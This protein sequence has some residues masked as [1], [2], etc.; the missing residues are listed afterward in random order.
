MESCELCNGS[1]WIEGGLSGLESYPC[2]ECNNKENK[3]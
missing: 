1:G 3:K 2:P